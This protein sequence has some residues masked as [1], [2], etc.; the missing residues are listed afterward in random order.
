MEKVTRPTGG[1]AARAE[2]VRER[3]RLRRQVCRA[4][5][6]LS[7]ESLSRLLDQPLRQ[8]ERF[9]VLRGERSAVELP[10]ETLGLLDAAL[11]LVLE[12]PHLGRGQACGQRRRRRRAAAGGSCW[13]RAAARRDG[14]GR[15]APAPRERAP[16]GATRSGRHRRG[17]GDRL[18][19]RRGR[20]VGSGTTGASVLGA[21]RARRGLE[22][23][24]R[25]GLR[26]W[27]G[28]AAPTAEIRAKHAH[29]VRA[30]MSA[31]SA[32]IL[33]IGACPGRRV[34]SGS[35]SCP[36]P[37]WNPRRP[38]RRAFARCGRPSRGR[39]P[40]RPPSSCSTG[41][42]SSRGSPAGIPVPWSATRICDPA[43]DGAP[44]RDDQRA[45]ARHRLDRVAHEVGAR[46]SDEPGV[47]RHARQAESRIEDDLDPGPGGLGRAHPR[48]VRQDRVDV[49]R[50]QPEVL[51]THEPEEALDHA[52]QS[53]DLVRDD[54]DVLGDLRRWRL[55]GLG[56]A[57]A[58]E[59][60]VD[61]HRV[62]RV[63]DLVSHAR[64]E[65]AQRRQLLR[66][67]QERL[68]GPGRLE[69]AQ[70]EQAPARLG[71]RTERISR[72]RPLVG[73]PRA[74]RERD[75]L[76]ERRGPSVEEGRGQLP[77]GW[78]EGRRPARE[79][80]GS[81]RPRSRSAL[82]LANATMPS[83]Q[84]RITAFWSRS[85]LPG[86]AS[87]ARAG[88]GLDT[89]SEALH[90]LGETP[91]VVA[92]PELDGSIAA[93]QALDPSGDS[94][95]VAEEHAPGAEAERDG[96][97]ER[98]CAEREASE[99]R[100]AEGLP[101]QARGHAYLH[102][103]EGP[104]ADADGEADLVDLRG[105][106]QHARELG[107]SRR[108]HVIQ[109]RAIGKLLPLESRVAVKEVRAR[110]RRL[111]RRR[112]RRGNNPRARRG[113]PGGSDPDRRLPPPR[114]PSPAGRAKPDG[115]AGARAGVP[116]P[117]RSRA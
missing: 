20:R 76:V 18:G 51:R 100:V 95:Q 39:C 68:D 89:L 28:P 43:G 7:S 23:Q 48:H 103:A 41:G 31:A 13:R 62:E 4:L 44:A 102:R 49:D 32:R 112:R 5:V 69:V 47:R 9:H 91:H 113:E 111:W 115:A 82:A 36:C 12:T 116:R 84:R 109:E 110:S 101:D 74:A 117:P 50:R 96:Q 30:R 66:V 22:G 35:P 73:L 16:E 86:P 75:R 25:R 71:G 98:S 107:Q 2:I 79:W 77:S 106:Q 52:V 90:P 45:A 94:A 78:P 72:N 40:I 60:E 70:Y 108:Q 57:R 15:L 92:G 81:V 46:L 19:R 33:I 93:G 59:L 14:A 54:V 42:R 8:P 38:G 17:L 85:T 88:G 26:L 63:L 105:T 29:P 24:R 1:S 99:K 6:V 21:G 114:V 11:C 83:G 80:P 37:R 65:T 27:P 34:G 67:A 58:K 56:E 55:C 10:E 87:P 64:R 3:A 97:A 61:P 53:L 104:I